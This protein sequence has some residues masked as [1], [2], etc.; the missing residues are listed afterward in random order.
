VKE[1][2]DF[3]ND[4]G[5]GAIGTPEDAIMQIERLWEQPNDGF[6]AFLQLAHDWAPAA[7]K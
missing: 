3:V 7:A 6:G 2:I 5:L 4:R 1:F